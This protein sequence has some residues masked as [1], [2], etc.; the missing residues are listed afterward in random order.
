MNVRPPPNWA[1]VSGPCNSGARGIGPAYLKLGR[2]VR[3]D[4]EGLE[5][6]LAQHVRTHTAN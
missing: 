4:A 5:A 2:A 1:S 6:W 3:Y